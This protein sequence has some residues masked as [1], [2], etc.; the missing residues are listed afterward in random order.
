MGV[1]LGKKDAQG[2]DGLEGKQLAGSGCGVCAAVSLRAQT[3]REERLAWKK[4]ALQVT[5]VGFQQAAHCST[6]PWSCSPTVAVWSDALSPLDSHGERQKGARRIRQWMQGV[7]AVEE[8][9]RAPG[10]MPNSREGA[11]AH[12]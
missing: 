7:F 4:A 12:T 11:W 3:H 5:G 6:D 8:G 10:M 2:K 9:W 1:S